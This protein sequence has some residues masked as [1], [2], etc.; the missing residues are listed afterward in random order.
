[1]DVIC[2]ENEMA[3]IRLFVKGNCY[4][5]AAS[6]FDRIPAEVATAYNLSPRLS[7]LLKLVMYQ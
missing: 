7:A 3:A 5:K 6:G 2:E 4:F 1:M